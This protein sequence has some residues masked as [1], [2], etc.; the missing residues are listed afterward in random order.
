M[1]YGTLIYLLRKLKHQSQSEFSIEINT[2]IQLSR[3]NNYVPNSLDGIS[4]VENNHSKYRNRAVKAVND[5]EFMR[6]LQQEFKNIYDNLNV[7][8]NNFRNH[9]AALLESRKAINASKYYESAVYGDIYQFLDDLFSKVKSCTNL[10]EQSEADFYQNLL[11][12]PT[13][14]IEHTNNLNVHNNA[15]ITYLPFPAPLQSTQ[16]ALPNE[17]HLKQ[18][19][20]QDDTSSTQSAL[21]IEIHSEQP[22]IQDDALPIQSEYL[23]STQPTIL[24]YFNVSHRNVQ[25]ISSSDIE[26]AKAFIQDFSEIVMNCLLRDPT[27]VPTEISFLDTLENTLNIWDFKITLISNESIK[28]DLLALHKAL[29]QYYNLFDFKFTRALEDNNFIFFRKD[30]KKS[31]QYFENIVSPKSLNIRQKISEL[32][33]K[34]IDKYK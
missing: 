12:F 23:D 10:D 30:T 22:P 33:T 29:K 2:S 13:P 26:I 16:S 3:I 28:V 19:P 18:S 8:I 17:I 7:D 11:K 20:I 1:K 31:R 15:P 6:L 24:K 27:A 4:R 5:T 34:I 21:P 14:N 9:I 25:N 32:W